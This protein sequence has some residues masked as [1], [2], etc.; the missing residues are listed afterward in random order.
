MH[1]HE[2]DSADE[3]FAW[4]GP[5]I[6]HEIEQWRITLN[7]A[8]TAELVDEARRIAG[9]TNE[10]TAQHAIDRG[11]FPLAAPALAKIEKEVMTGRGFALLKSPATLDDSTLKAYYWVLMSLMGRPLS[12]NSHGQRLRDVVDTG[13][14]MGEQRVRGYETNAALKY[15]TDRC[16]MVGLLCLR[17]S[18]SGGLSSIASSI[19]V[20]K[21]L[22]A[23]QP[24]LIAPLVNGVNFMSIEEGGDISVKRVPVFSVSGGALSCRYSRNSFATAIR[25]GVPYTELEKAALDAVD[26]LAEDARFR[27]DMDLERG[28]IQII[29]NY[30]TLHSRTEFK[31][32]PETERR[33]CMVRVWLQTD[34]VRPVLRDFDD[35]RGIPVTLVSAQQ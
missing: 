24:E 14:K 10:E 4:S 8:V 29:N 28:D 30:T 31:D 2:I 7:P 15:H 32:W 19:T 13:K 25:Q 27:L 3:S 23:R 18:M 6:A 16:D 22:A 1:L 11:R 5:N 33:R 21:E 12:Q 34:T 20:Y 35:Y 9:S 17:K 26:Q